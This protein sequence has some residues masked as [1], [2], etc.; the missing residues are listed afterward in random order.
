MALLEAIKNVMLIIAF[1][2]SI[3]FSADFP[4]TV[5][6]DKVGVMFMAGDIT[7]KSGTRY[8]HIRYKYVNKYAEE[9]FVKIL[10]MKSAE[11]DSYILMKNFC[12][13]FHA[14][15]VSKKIG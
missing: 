2:K 1:S 5:R 11:N 9:K 6:V 13:E 7:A 10:F 14:K 3:K 8:V 15:H 12:G 4:V